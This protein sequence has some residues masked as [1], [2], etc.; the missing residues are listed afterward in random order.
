MDSMQPVRHLLLGICFLGLSAGLSA[1]V[2]ADSLR[3]QHLE[4]CGDVFAQEQQEF[5]I[6]TTGKIT[7]KNLQIHLED[8]TR[9]NRK[10]TSCAL[11]SIRRIIKAARF[12]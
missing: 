9:C 8:L 1:Q 10:E 3:I 6:S 11:K 12:G 2:W 5:C 7:A 4:R